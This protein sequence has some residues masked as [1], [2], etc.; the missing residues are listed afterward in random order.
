M[1]LNAVLSSIKYIKDLGF[2]GFTRWFFL[3]FFYTYFYC[4]LL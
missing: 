1:G 3:P 4:Y 2:I